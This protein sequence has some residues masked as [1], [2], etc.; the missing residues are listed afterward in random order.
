MSHKKKLEPAWLI[1]LGALEG[2]AGWPESCMGTARKRDHCTEEKVPK[3]RGRPDWGE[4]GW[5]W[6]E[7]V[8][9]LAGSRGTKYPQIK[10]SGL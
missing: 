7:G 8:R 1:L 6:Q 4:G 5:D 9:R 2:R 10:M 3:V